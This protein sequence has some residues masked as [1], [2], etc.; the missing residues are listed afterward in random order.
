M[1]DTGIGMDKEFI[2]KLFDA[3][4][5]EDATMT[6]EYGGSGLGMAITKS[7]IEMMDGN[8]VVE[9]EK[10][11]GST[12]TVTVK[13]G[14]SD[15]TMIREDLGFLL[16]KLHVLIVDDDP[17]ACE[18]ARLVLEN[19][20]ISSDI[21]TGSSEAYNRVRQKWDEGEPYNLIL[22]DYRMPE[23]DGIELAE[24]I[25]MFDEG[26][27]AII[28]MTGHDFDDMV[29]EARK[30][31]VDGLVSK[32]LFA[33]SLVR[34]IQNV[35]RQRSGASDSAEG[36]G[37][38]AVSGATAGRGGASGFV[39]EANGESILS[40]DIAPDKEEEFDLEGLHVMM[41][42]DIEM[43]AEILKDILEMEGITTEHARNGQSAV[44]MFTAGEPGHFDA[45][46]MDIRMPVM[47][48]LTAAKTIRAL[49]RPDAKTVPII[50]MTANAFDEDVRNSLEAGMNEHLSK[51]I[52]P[53]K[54]Y[55]TLTRFAK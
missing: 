8:V 28:I 42:E 34:E 19:S 13:L 17:V 23:A 7:F 14:Y 43:N 32:P 46:L 49:D 6:N 39:R 4:S 44:D 38:M 53:D 37:G 1:K 50:A 21:C 20:G 27:T 22:T 33:D 11:V 26:K 29:D 18:H 55:E 9:S 48:G 15:R 47:D 24:D 35:M 10:G 30:E 40:V 52:D 16:D 41:A 31:G 25:R 12:F 36:T 2:P 5:Q 3:F 51:P 54:L 45:I